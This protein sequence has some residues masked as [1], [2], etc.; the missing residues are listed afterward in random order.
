MR[1]S[2]LFSNQDSFE[3][4]IKERE[5]PIEHTLFQQETHRYIAAQ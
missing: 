4:S 2:L 3:F 5:F 1:S